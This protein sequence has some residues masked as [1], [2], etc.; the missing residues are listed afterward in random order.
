MT[1]NLLPSVDVH[2]MNILLI[3]DAGWNLYLKPPKTCIVIGDVMTLEATEEAGIYHQWK[4]IYTRMTDEWSIYKRC[5]KY[6]KVPQLP[7]LFDM[8]RANNMHGSVV[9]A[10]ACQIPVILAPFIL[11][12][13]VINLAA[14]VGRA[15]SKARPLST[16]FLCTEYSVHPCEI[17]ATYIPRKDC[18]DVLALAYTNRSFLAY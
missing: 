5:T 12:M 10:L 17:I 16:I 18:D 7:V 3:V 9:K 6:S 4:R 2:M 1:T 14:Q 13:I 8:E 15:F 11:C